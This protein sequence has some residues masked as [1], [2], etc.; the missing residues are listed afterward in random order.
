MKSSVAIAISLACAAAGF[1]GGRLSQSP[2]PS[3]S[4]G[5]ATAQET[6]SKD[7]GA[8]E[9]AEKSSNKSSARRSSSRSNKPVSS[10]L[11]ASL[12]EVVNSFNNQDLTMPDGSQSELLLFDLSKLE[13]V[14]SSIDKASEAE[15]AELKE[16]VRTNEESSED[17]LILQT[18][19]SLPLLAREIQ[20]HGA[21]ALDDE[22][23]KALEDPVETNIEETLPTMI[24]TL[25]LQNPTEAEE[26]L[27]TYAKRTDTDELIIDNDELRAA[28]DKAKQDSSGSK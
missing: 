28:I 3:G 22:V 20:L 8:R 5:D 6:K 4:R 10:P 7:G 25:A 19:I 17:A 9:R 24:Y 12:Q 18:L 21:R 11:A 27:E 15:L 23:T 2:G 1:F 13:R 26:W 14:M 16:L